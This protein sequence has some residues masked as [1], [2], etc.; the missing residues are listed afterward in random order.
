MSI[1]QPF[2]CR[3]CFTLVAGMIVLLALICGGGCGQPASPTTK[4]GSTNALR[5][6]NHVA[7]LV[8]AGKTNLYAETNSVF[9]DK[10]K[11]GRDPFF[12]QSNRR[13]GV[14]GSPPP[15][16]HKSSISHGEN[17]KA[18]GEGAK[19][20]PPLESFLKLSSIIQAGGRKI[21]SISGRTMEAGNDVTVHLPTGLS[22]RVHCIEIDATT[23]VVTLDDKPERKTLYLKH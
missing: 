15:P 2:A 21:A 5:A 1:A 8:G 13:W 12:P 6:T 22:V 10:R 4:N 18:E 19:A 14:T 7:A 23:V 16:M 3:S 20:P 17:A 9:D 11:E